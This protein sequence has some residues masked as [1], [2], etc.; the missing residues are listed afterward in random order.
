MLQDC[1]TLSQP[2]EL[3]GVPLET[4]NCF[5]YLGS[6]ISSDCNV[7]AEVNARINKARIT[8]ANLLVIFGTREAFH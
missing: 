3:N 5:T 4:V 8:F 1:P 2:L 6:C 7:S